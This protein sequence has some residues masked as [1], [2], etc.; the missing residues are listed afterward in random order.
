EVQWSR[1]QGRSLSRPELN[2]LAQRLR[3]QT[4]TITSLLR[5]QSIDYEAVGLVRDALGDVAGGLDS[6]AETLNP[7]TLG[8]LGSGLGETA[9][10][11]EERVVPSAKQAA[12]RLHELD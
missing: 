5:K 9:K 1:Q 8:Q 12:D 11:L 3:E 6:L 2:E 10:F 4:E 7:A